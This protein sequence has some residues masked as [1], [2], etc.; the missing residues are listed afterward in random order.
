V[1]RYYLK[2]CL[3]RYT[4]LLFGV[5]FSFT[6]SVPALGDKTAVTIYTYRSSESVAD[7]RY[8]YDTALLNLALEKTQSEF[9]PYA[10]VASPAM[11]FSRAILLAQRNTLPNF[12]IKLSYANEGYGLSYVPF[13]VD[14]GIVGYRVCFTAK[15]NL[16]RVAKIRSIADLKEMSFGVGIGWADVDV[17]R[18]QNFDVVQVALYE[19]LFR[20]TAIGRLDLFCRGVNEFLDEWNTNKNTENFAYDKT[21]AI[22]YPL[23]R[24][25]FTNEK[26]TLAVERFEK[27]LKIAYNDG[28]LLSLWREHYKESIQFANLP[29]R[30][31]FKLSNPTL[32]D[33]SVEYEHYL[34]D[35]FDPENT[36]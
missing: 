5:L 33:L 27:G 22:H 34:F 13:P 12:M 6:L 2:S 28:S 31:I 17:L 21:M 36:F 11:N 14:L 25:F 1:F 7:S 4:A 35:P 26:N 18:S 23:P 16:Q 10:L 24:F 32:K 3:V 9:G 15:S 29:A 20:M 19:S 30:R 8:D